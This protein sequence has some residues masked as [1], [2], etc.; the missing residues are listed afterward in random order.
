MATAKAI[1]VGSNNPYPGIPALSPRVPNSAGFRLWKMMND[2]CGISA[3]EYER[4]FRR[5]NWDEC[6][7]GP[8]FLQGSEVVVLGEEVRKLLFLPKVFLHPVVRYGSTFR[9]IPHPS[10]RCHYYNNKLCRD[11]VAM[12]LEDMIR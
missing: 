12:M 1:I 3:V 5:C 8:T 4:A 6:Q 2:W 11:L 9:Q 7:G 10:G